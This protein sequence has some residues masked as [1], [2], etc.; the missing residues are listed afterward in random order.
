[1]PWSGWPAA[2]APNA[3]GSG[4][5]LEIAKSQLRDYQAR[6]GA[7]FVHDAY[8]SELTA[9]RDQIKMSLSGA[10]A[11]PGSEPKA[12]PSELAEQIKALK[13]RNT[14]EATPERAGIRRTEAEEPVTLRI[15][16]RAET[17]SDPPQQGPGEWEVA[18]LAELRKG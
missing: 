15:R 12:S 2:T 10:T 16:R 13:A 11:E 8:L 1:M 17:I 4:N 7:P 6:L 18:D 14:I 9:L 5:D 3:T